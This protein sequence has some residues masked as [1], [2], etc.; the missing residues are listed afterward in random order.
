MIVA[1]S[2]TFDVGRRSNSAEFGARF[3]S[4]TLCTFSCLVA[5]AVPWFPTP[6]LFGDD[7]VGPLHK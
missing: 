5:T 3:G 7:P 1:R 2:S 6:A 4:H